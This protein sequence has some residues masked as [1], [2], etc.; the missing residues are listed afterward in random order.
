[1]INLYQSF[2]N[3]TIEKSGKNFIQVKMTSEIGEPKS[4]LVTL[5][6]KQ[7][8]YQDILLDDI[9]VSIFMKT[10]NPMKS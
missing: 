6:F 5:Y 10:S 8:D 2:S 1:M 3:V 7:S 4:L 9:N